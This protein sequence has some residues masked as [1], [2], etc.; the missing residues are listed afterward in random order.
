[1][2][3][4]EAIASVKETTSTVFKQLYVVWIA[5]AGTYDVLEGRN[6]RLHEVGQTPGGS[7]NAATHL[8][9]QGK[10]NVCKRRMGQ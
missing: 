3:Q 9:T 6:V 5:S 1:M 4:D 10:V 7:R 8:V 2:T